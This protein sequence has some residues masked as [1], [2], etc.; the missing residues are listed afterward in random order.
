MIKALST[1]KPQEARIVILGS[2]AMTAILLYQ[3]AWLPANQ[4]IERLEG[5]VNKQQT[6]E[7]WMTASAREIQQIRPSS[8][9]ANSNKNRPSGSLLTLTDTT[10]RQFRLQKALK[11]VEPESQNSVRI[12]IEQANFDDLIQW[13]E[14]LSSRHHI[15]ASKA[16]ISKQNASGIVDARLTLTRP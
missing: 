6:T 7:K 2:I 8:S 11:R 4:S 12:W 1:L 3:L 16:T 5:I 9:A 15:T 14:A 10:A 13:L